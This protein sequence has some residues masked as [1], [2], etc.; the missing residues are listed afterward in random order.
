[1]N[2]VILTGRLTKDV[3]IRVSDAGENSTKIA[4]F[5]LAVARRFKRDDQPDA[6]FPNC[7]AFGKTA[8]FLD[9]YGKKGVKFEV[10]GR[11]QTGSYEDKETGKTIYTTDVVVESITF[12]ESKGSGNGSNGENSSGTSASNGDG[13]M[14]I[15]DGIDEELPF[16]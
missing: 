11:L 10:E 4:R 16:N 13:F 7:V 2:K 9:Q 6:D 1:M 14:N 5:N 12:A 8:E 15:P 3:T